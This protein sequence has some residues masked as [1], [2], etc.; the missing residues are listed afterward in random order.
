MYISRPRT[1]YDLP[2]VLR[3]VPVRLN[4]GGDLPREDAYIQAARLGLEIDNDLR[5]SSD[6]LQKLV[7]APPREYRPY[8]PPFRHSDLVPDASPTHIN[9]LDDMP[10]L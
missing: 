3:D 5:V 7:S 4:L 6:R 10:L 1:A 8:L 9:S 2:S